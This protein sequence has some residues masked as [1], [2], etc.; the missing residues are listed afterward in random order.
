MSENEV[1]GSLITHP[2]DT[3]VGNENR[4]ANRVHARNG[5]PASVA[6]SDSG[7]VSEICSNHGSH[8][9]GSVTDRLLEIRRWIGDRRSADT[10]DVN[11]TLLTVAVG[12]DRTDSSSERPLDSPLESF[13]Q[14]GA[15]S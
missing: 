14:I 3:K 10:G 15:Q 2:P 8:G 12:R 11:V 5:Y 9:G 1:P 6:E 7:A 13:D 4:V